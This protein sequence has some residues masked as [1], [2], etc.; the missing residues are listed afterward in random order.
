MKKG[1]TPKA[2]ETM[3]EFMAFALAMEREAVDRYTDFADTMETHNNREVAAMF[4]TM[5]G[6]EAKHAAQIM[7]E[8]GWTE[9]TRLPEVQLN[10]PGFEA[11][12]T[13]PFDEVHYLMRPYHA[14]KIA[15]AAE[16]RA[17]RFFAELARVTSSDSVRRAAQE[18][19]AEE[20]EHAQMVKQW[21]TKVPTPERNWAEDPDPPRQD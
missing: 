16:E 5:A 3:E 15:L 8:M 18:M 20:A 9:A 10:W 14:L 6:Y 1:Q 11:P 17:E 2:P 19:Q 13:V 4:R 7:A 21:M 12:E